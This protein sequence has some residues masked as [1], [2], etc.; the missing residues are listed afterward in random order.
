MKSLLIFLNVHNRGE[1]GEREAVPDQ[2][3]KPAQQRDKA[4]AH[5]HQDTQVPS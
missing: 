3:D 5:R 2:Q 1:D 4:T